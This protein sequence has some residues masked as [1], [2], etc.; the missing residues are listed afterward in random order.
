MF[1]ERLR[2][3]VVDASLA[4]ALFAAAVLELLTD[5]STESLGA[6]VVA[7]T[8]TTL[9]LAW[10][11]IA[12]LTIMAI[13]V[14]GYVIGVAAGMDPENQV[15][16]T[17]AP[18]LAFY[19]VG[20][21]SSVLRIAVAAAIAL[22]GYVPVLVLAGADAEGLVYT[23]VG[24]VVALLAGAAVRVMGLES[25]VL[26]ARA[27][28]LEIERD[29]KAR[30]AVAAERA[31][32]ARELHDVIGHSIS[33]MGLQAGAVRRV[34][35]PGHEEERNA[36]LG[37]ERLGRDAV[38]EMHGLLG[39]LREEGDVSANGAPPSMERVEDLVADMRR[40]GLD[41]EL[42][43]EEGLRLEELTPGR[44]LAAYRIL[45]EALTNALRHAPSA[46]VQASLRRTPTGVEIEVVDDGSDVPSE[47]DH[48]GHGLVGMRERVALYGGTL[49]VGPCVDRG[50]AVRAHLP[51][52]A[53]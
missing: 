27:A 40:A 49:D 45:Q 25:D 10:R 28:E 2:P 11:N 8:L 26:A 5:S 1:P 46:H 6:E 23:V 3:G 4:T 14:G 9:P 53:T 52:A 51:T 13:T 30:E 43:V 20:N 39:F 19:T 44:A 48:G 21:R 42:R 32:I 31:R 36:L 34:L 7:A 17:V 29:V 18:M 12:P 50:F 41:V 22:V 38:A 16:P 33:V 37:I 15:V 24:L 35:E 47:G